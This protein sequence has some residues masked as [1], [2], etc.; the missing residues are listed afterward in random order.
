MFK[1]KCLKK[2][3]LIHAT[4]VVTSYT[5]THAVFLF[6]VKGKEEETEL[7][8]QKKVGGVDLCSYLNFRYSNLREQLSQKATSA[9][10]GSEWLDFS[11][12]EL[13]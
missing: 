6:G 13:G 9:S 12:P 10:Q 4:Q 8:L 5:I 11:V 7:Y 3:K 2:R 1:Q